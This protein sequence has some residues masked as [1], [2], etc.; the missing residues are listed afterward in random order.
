M[1][2]AHEFE[3][4]LI[5]MQSE[6]RTAGEHARDLGERSAQLEAEHAQQGSA[7]QQSQ[8]DVGRLQGEVKSLADAL[9]QRDSDLQV[10]SSASSFLT[11]VCQLQRP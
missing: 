11:Q 2:E 7:M 10:R 9:A 3:S 5:C 8:S 1:C 6:L 4:F